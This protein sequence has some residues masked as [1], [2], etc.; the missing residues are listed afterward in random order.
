MN[1][2]P[3]RFQR[4]PKS[5]VL[6][7]YISRRYSAYGYRKEKAI[8][9]NPEFQPEHTRD[10]YRWIENV[11]K[12]LRFV[13]TS[14]EINRRLPLGWFTDQWQD[15]T[16]SG[17]VYQLPGRDGEPLF[18]PAVSDPC[19]PDSACLN[20]SSL[21]SDK[22][23]A[24]RWADH[25]AEMWAESERAF[26]EKEEMEAR[27]EEIGDEIKGLYSEFRRVARELRANCDRISGVQVVRELVREKWEDTKEA[28]HE[29][30]AER[31]KLERGW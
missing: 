10:R 31:L 13:G 14:H 18:V 19:N 17:E 22:E 5:Q 23:D 11:S 4:G 20:F 6:S 25:M 28:I 24:A 3:E 26:R 7:N 29:L 9:Y 16:V 8:G 12:G 21:T 27:I 1:Q 30:R 2:L 15:E